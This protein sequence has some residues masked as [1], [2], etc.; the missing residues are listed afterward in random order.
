MNFHLSFP[1]LP[2]SFK[3]QHGNKISL[4]GSCFSDSM[5]SHFVNSGFEVNANPFGTVF[6]PSVIARVIS[7]SM[8]ETDENDLFQRGDLYFSW[9]AAGKL[10]GNSSDELKQN[11]LEARSYFRDFLKKCDVLIITF[12]TAWGYELKSTKKIVANCHKMHADLFEKKLMSVDPELEIWRN[13]VEKLNRYNPLLK[14][15]FTVSPVRHKKDGLI[16]NNRSKGR[17]IE[18]VHRLNEI[19]TTNY[20]P[21]YEIIIDELRDYRFFKEDRVHPTDEAVN[22]VWERLEESYFSDHTREIAQKVRQLHVAF[23]HKS[24]HPESED[25]VVRR[26][27]VKVRL[28]ELLRMHPAVYWL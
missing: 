15:V 3:I 25:D 24:L 16:E 2:S 13:L 27:R 18:L 22:Y 6:H 1:I 20:F 14:I 9:N 17:L 23:D 7:D 5:S 26:E 8:E 4:I 21:S 12:G 10:Y 28:K 11:I 19:T